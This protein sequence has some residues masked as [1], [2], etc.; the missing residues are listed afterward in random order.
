MDRKKYDRKKRRAYIRVNKNLVIANTKLKYKNIYKYT[1][2]C[3]NSKAKSINDVKREAKTES[4]HYL[5]LVH[6]NKKENKKT[7]K[8]KQKKL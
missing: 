5:V 6:L 8:R 1:K 2:T 7:Y 3:E 4:N